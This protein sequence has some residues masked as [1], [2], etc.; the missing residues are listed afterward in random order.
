MLIVRNIPLY[1]KISAEILKQIRAGKFPE[2]TLP[3]EEQLSVSMG[4]SKH[5]VREALTELTSLSYISKRHGVGNI[6]MR[7]VLDTQFRI[8]ANMNFIQL[9]SSAGY[10]ASLEQM[11]FRVENI[12]L[13]QF[14]KQTYYAYDEIMY[15][16]ASPATEH[17]IY[18]PT[19]IFN[20]QNAI[21]ECPEESL[22]D[23]FSKHRITVLHSIVEF[24]PEIS[25][26]KTI[27][28]FGLLEP[29]AINTWKEIIYDINDRPICCTKIKFNPRIFPLRMVR[30]DFD[31]ID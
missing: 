14:P 31:I 29:R 9:L 5:T 7:S 11:N 3:S 22:F 23:F 8:D 15:A 20:N 30:K 1:K 28:L 21:T 24:V 17:S 16:D 12:E 10:K 6:M 13:L 18:I 25:D 27:E 19:N 26:Q 4:V 2:E